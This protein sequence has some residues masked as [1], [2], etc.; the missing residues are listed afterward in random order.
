[1]FANSNFDPFT[2]SRAPPLDA[3]K[4]KGVDSPRPP[5][6]PMEDPDADDITLGSRILGA[7]VG[8]NLGNS[9]KAG[10]Q[11]TGLAR[12]TPFSLEACSELQVQ[13]PP[14]PLEA[15]ATAKTS[16]TDGMDNFVA[17]ILRNPTSILPGDWKLEGRSYLA[18]DNEAVQP[19]APVVPTI[20]PTPPVAEPVPAPMTMPTPQPAPADDAAA[21][22]QES[23]IRMQE[24]QE[25]IARLRMQ[26]ESMDGNGKTGGSF[27]TS[28]A[29]FGVPPASATEMETAPLLHAGAFA[30]GADSLG[31]SLN[32]VRVVE[33]SQPEHALQ[34]VSTLL[35]DGAGF[36]VLAENGA[37]ETAGAVLTTAIFAGIGAVLFEYVATNKDAPI[38]DPLLSGLWSSFHSAVRSAS[39]LTGKAANTVSK[40]LPFF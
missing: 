3:T 36:A 12:C 6:S 38:P 32:G 30:D 34:H 17:N 19:A 22:L 25:S 40:A 14:V 5:P 15:E 18:P 10:L 29:P 13:P 37:A 9:I 16:A 20:L 35:E 8:G 26:I 28:S 33:Y 23:A 11:E 7:F 4:A 21:T 31:S 1:V 39:R 27:P 2:T 24:L